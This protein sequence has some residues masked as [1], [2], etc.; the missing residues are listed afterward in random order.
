[1]G[2]RDANFYAVVNG[3]RA[4]VTVFVETGSGSLAHEIRMILCKTDIILFAKT[5]AAILYTMSSKHIA[6]LFLINF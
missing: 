1:M 6:R 3:I 5:F 2:R 4:G